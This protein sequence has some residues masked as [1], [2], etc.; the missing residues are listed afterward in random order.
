MSRSFRIP[1]LATAV[2]LAAGACGDGPTETSGDPLSEAEVQEVA[3]EIFAE[4][5]G[6]F[7]GDFSPRQSALLPAGLNLS[8]TASVPIHVTIDESGPCGGDGT[9]SVSGSIDGQV[10]D[11]SGEGNLE[12]DITQG[13][14]DCVIEGEL[15]SYTVSGQPNIHLTGSFEAAEQSLSGSFT[16]VGGFAF[17]VDDGRSGTCGVDVTAT[18]NISGDSFSSTAQGTVCGVTV[19]NEVIFGN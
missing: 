2:A 12:F 5:S 1:A 13:F 6:I 9:A 15:H 7:S 14:N 19:N 11:A 3:A 10:D 4:L 17:T 18:V 8:V 16:L